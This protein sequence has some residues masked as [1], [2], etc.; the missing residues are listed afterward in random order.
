MQF[1][2]GRLDF[3]EVFKT[4]L[5]ICEELKLDPFSLCKAG[6][7]YHHSGDG[8]FGQRANADYAI[9]KRLIVPPLLVLRSDGSG[10]MPRALLE[11]IEKVLESRRN[12]APITG[13]LG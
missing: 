8:R 4:Q 1:G 9:H 5:I 11:R 12:R 13:Q 2:P 6:Q 3:A 10:S 7:Y